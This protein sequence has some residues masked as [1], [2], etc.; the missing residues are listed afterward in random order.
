MRP[1]RHTLPVLLLL[2]SVAAPLRA[3]AASPARRER[4]HRAKLCA[5]FDRSLIHISAPTR[6]D[7]IS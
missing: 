1:L 3:E 4:A 6:P 5:V 7:K 2:A